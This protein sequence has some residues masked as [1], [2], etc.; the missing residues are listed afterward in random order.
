MDLKDEIHWLYIELMEE[1]RDN[2]TILEHLLAL[3]QIVYGKQKTLKIE[4]DHGFWPHSGATKFKCSLDN[5]GWSL[6]HR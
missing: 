3:L 1:T 6:K 2:Q 5:N 4:I